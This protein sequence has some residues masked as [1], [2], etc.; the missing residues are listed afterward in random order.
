MRRFRIY[1]IELDNLS[2][3]DVFEYTKRLGGELDVDFEILPW[4]TKRPLDASRDWPW[5]DTVTTPQGKPAYLTDYIIDDNPPA[6]E[7]CWKRLDDRTWAIVMCTRHLTGKE[8]GGYLNF[9]FGESFSRTHRIVVSTCNFDKHEKAA[10]FPIVV[11]HEFGHLLYIPDPR[12]KDGLDNTMCVHCA[13]ETCL[14]RTI[15]SVD[16]V[17]D[18]KLKIGESGQLLCTKCRKE[19]AVLQVASLR[20]D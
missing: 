19:Y 18:L 12:R 20:K 17:R 15:E 16:D 8:N 3:D 14:M 6:L 9:V 1:S 10:C 5:Q 11:A 2:C 7:G 4:D 13:N